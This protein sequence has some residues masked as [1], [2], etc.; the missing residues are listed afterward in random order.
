M[1]ISVPQLQNYMDAGLNILITG[2]AGTGKTAMLQQASAN[3]GLKMK[4]YSA[5]T[6][7]PFA[8]LVGI[9]VPDK[10]AKTVEYYRPRDVDSAEVIF[11]DE[12]NRADTKTLNAVFEIIQFRSINGEPLPNLKCVVAAINPVAEGYDTDEL[13]TALVDRFDVYLESKVEADYQYLKAKFGEAYARAGVTLF[14]EYQKSYNSAKRSKQ[15]DLGYFSP[16]RLE[17]LMEIFQKFPK[18]E[19]VRAVLPS[20]VT[21]SAKATAVAFNDALNASQAVAKGAA[22]AQKAMGFADPAK[23]IADQLKLQ[24]ADMRRKANSQGFLEA[25]RWAR[26]NDPA[27]AQK[28]LTALAPA[29]NYGVGHNTINQV[30]GEAVQDFNPSQKRILTNG[31]DWNKKDRTFKALGWV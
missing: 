7:D 15:N 23:A 22:A 18:A 12:L 26:T 10:D 17:K 31:W 27:A 20:D 29:L 30:W 9:P 14:N 4:Y 3:L 11:M 8:D 16:R 2:E 21:V 1:A 28:L 25:Y 24:P 13:D 5:S 19:T 6:L